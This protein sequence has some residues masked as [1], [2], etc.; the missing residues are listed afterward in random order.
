MSY[1]LPI[2]NIG[3]IEVSS[4]E[5]RNFR[6][7]KNSTFITNGEHTVIRSFTSI[8]PEVTYEDKLRMLRF[9]K[10]S[11]GSV[12]SADGFTKSD[13]Y[14]TEQLESNVGYRIVG[15]TIITSGNSVNIHLKTSTGREILP[16]YSSQSNKGSVSGNISFIVG[17]AEDIVVSIDS[18]GPG[19]NVF[20]GVSYDIERCNLSLVLPQ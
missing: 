13:L 4:I 18:L 7:S 2:D 12:L 20:V 16:L 19:N 14:G 10:I 6:Q 9:L 11:K 15:I 3:R 5:D 1:K 17:P 8:L